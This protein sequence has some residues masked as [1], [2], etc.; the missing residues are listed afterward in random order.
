MAAATAFYIAFSYG[1]EKI[2]VAH[3]LSEGQADAL[4]QELMQAMGHK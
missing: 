3:N 2:V 1:N 4:F